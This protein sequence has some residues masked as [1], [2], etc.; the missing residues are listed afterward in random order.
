MA[1]KRSVTAHSRE[2]LTKEI[3]RIDH[4]LVKLMNERATTVQQLADIA[5]DSPDETR[6][7][8][9][10]SAD[11]FTT[12]GGPLDERA[13]RATFRE[14]ASGCQSLVK[15]L[16]VAYLG[17]LYS[18]SYLATIERFG[19]HAELAPVST[20]AAVFEELN[21][22]H[23]DFGVVPLENST[24]GR[25]VDTLGMFARMP[26]RICGEVQLRIHHNLLAKCP[27][28]EIQEVYSKPQALSQ[29]RD[30][31]AKHLPTARMVEMTSTAAAAQ[32]ASE[33][34]GAA[35]VASRLAA[36]N[37]G[38]DLVAEDIEDNQH[39]VTRFV[40]IGGDTARPTGRDK[41]AV[42]FEIPH[43]PGSLADAMAIF[44]RE[45]LNMTW[46]ESFPMAGGNSEY[47]FFVELEGH[48]TETKL[49]RA[50]QLLSK[51]TVRFRDLGLLRHDRPRR[52]MW[53][54]HIV[55][56]S[57][58]RGFPPKPLP[59]TVSVTFARPKRHSNGG[60][61]EKAFQFSF[62]HAS[63]ARC[64]EAEATN[65]LPKVQRCR[66]D[67]CHLPDVRVLHGAHRGRVGRGGVLSKVAFLFPG[68]GAQSVGMG[69]EA[70]DKLPAVGDLFERASDILNYDL[71]Q[72]CFDGPAEK[73]D[74]TVYSQPALFVCG[75]AGVELLKAE[76]PDLLRSV[77]ATAGL[78]LGEYTALV[79]AR[80]M[81]FETGL[82]VVKTRGEAMQAAADAIPSGMVSLLGL[83]LDA[84]EELCNQARGD[85]VLE[86][87]N[88]LCPGNTVVSGSKEAC[89]RIAEL[90]VQAGAM[91]AIPLSVA[92]AF[93]TQIM[94]PALEQ[95]A[96]A[97]EAATI[98]A[99][100]IPVISNVDGR[101]HSDPEEIR[102]LLVQQVVS[103]VRWEDSMR[104]LLAEGFDLF[105]EVGPGRVLRGLLR[106]INRKT[107]CEGVA[108]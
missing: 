24:D 47:L 42:M 59:R 7:V 53:L 54:T 87:A 106:R 37:Y 80:A 25:V 4:Q 14:L 38:L 60:S 105:Y 46:I 19:S 85:D 72:L 77:S 61:K 10:P 103:P 28:D 5:E 17:P 107:K 66:A 48:Q 57:T 9:P 8:A 63:L 33:K 88:Y 75:L 11:V 97:L 21:R 68:Q 26:V 39:N 67:S 62:R 23:A 1:K 20:I 31:L 78:S 52:L 92:G 35:A 65:F 101:S 84:I 79:F 27:R 55:R 96:G 93:H 3:D 58:M 36:S 89:Q 16:R 76:S 32:L 29:C 13:L 100:E 49:D 104:H 34:P 82:R 102:S 15:P 41:T 6:L 108:V 69:R 56:I 70:C 74:S 64:I 91:K 44:K 43:Q 90:A 94:K 86:I 22:R 99:P 18:Y 40:V 83:E 81:D 45:Q 2:Q 95:L 71:A 51:K 50:L 30:W 73:L 98:S 12:T